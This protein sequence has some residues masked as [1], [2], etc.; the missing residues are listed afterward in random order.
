MKKHRRYFWF[1]LLLA[2]GIVLAL[3]LLAN[4]VLQYYYVSKKIVLNH[5]EHE[6]R[7]QVA[8]LE[9]QARRT[10]IQS[11]SE[12]S[13]W[14]ENVPNKDEHK[15]AWIRV[16]D[17][18]G[19]TISQTGILGGAP[20]TGEEIWSR[21][22]KRESVS[23]V[24]ETPGGEVLLT[25]MPVHVPLGEI[26]PASG[27]RPPLIEMALYLD[28]AD[29]ILL[30]L[31]WIFII[32][33]AVALAL[34]VSLI[35][36]GRRFRVYFGAKQLEEQ[37]TLA[38]SVQQ[39]LQPSLQA[40]RPHLEVAAECTPAWQVGGDFYDIFSAD[41]ER[42]AVALGDVSG[43]GL[44]AA[45]LMALIHGALRSSSWHCGRKDHEESSERLNE[46]L[47]THSSQSQFASMFW[48]YFDPKINLLQYVNAGH[49]PPLLLQ[50]DSDG[51]LQISRLDGGGPVLG[52]LPNAR[53]HQSEFSFRPG[54]LLILYSDGVVEA[55]NESGE[56]FGEDRLCAAIERRS[57]GTAEEIRRGIRDD[58]SA[59]L[60]SVQPEDD[61]TLLVVRAQGT[62]PAVEVLDA[63]R[64]PA[65]PIAV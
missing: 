56:E 20:L 16:V 31:R 53:Y 22:A 30:S 3:T 23:E 48:C 59:F 21:L 26:A 44:P 36:I 4:S 25:V 5:L 15:I 8:A 18:N 47:R 61:L 29:A 37:M 65:E 17:P 7:T 41:G 64:Q 13:Q 19:E 11:T 60:G 63:I 38:R 54:D 52:L 55:A 1:K 6:A 43:K 62:V 33:C 45:L 46:L 51:D 9:Q 42:I 50:R 58:L 12:I 40:A 10:P 35:L 27:H 2:L 32:N 14:I 28:S 24:R 49:C 57:T 39:E 34:S